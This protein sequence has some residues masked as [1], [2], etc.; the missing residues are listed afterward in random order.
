MSYEIVTTKTIYSD[1]GFGWV[2]RPDGDD[3]GI[4][5]A[6]F[7]PNQE[8]GKPPSVISSDAVPALIESMAEVVV[9]AFPEERSNVIK[10]LQ[11]A[12]Q[13]LQKDP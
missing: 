2:V 9:E 3:I 12:L 7:E 8:P 13:K 5:I 11:T 6:Y 1:Y 10:A 4:G